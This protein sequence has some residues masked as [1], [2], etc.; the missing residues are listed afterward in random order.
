M[1]GT[2]DF[3]PWA[4]GGGANVLTAAAYAALA[5]R[6]LGAQTGTAVSA[7]FNT[8]MRQAS[9]ITSALAQWMA[10]NGINV[11]DDGILAD[12]VVD[13]NGQLRGTVVASITAL[14]ARLKTG[15]P[16][17]FVLGYYTAG[18]GGGGEY[19]YDSADITSADNGGTVIVAADGG[20]WK[21]Q[22]QGLITPEQFGAVGNG[23]ADDTASINACFAAVAAFVGQNTGDITQRRKYLPVLCT[24][25]YKLTTQVT[26]PA[27]VMVACE[28]GIFVNALVSTTTFCMVFAAGSHCFRLNI[29]AAG[30]SGAQLGTAGAYCDMIIGTVRVTNAGTGAS[31]I[32]SRIIGSRF[33]VEDIEV[34]GGFVGVD[35]GDGTVNGARL[36]NIDSL[37]STLSA[38]GVRFGS[39]TEEVNLPNL[40]VDTPTTTGIQA[41]GSRGIRVKGTIFGDDTRAVTPCTSGYAAIL[42]NT[43]ALSD[44]DLDLLVNNTASVD[45]TTGTAIKISNCS[46][47]VIRFSASRS[48]LSTGNA[49]R[50]K[51]AVEYGV[52]NAATL[53]V[54]VN[55]DP[56][57][58]TVVGTQVGGLE[59][60]GNPNSKFP[61][62]SATVATNA[63]TIGVAA[64]LAFDFRSATLGSGTPNTVIGTPA[65][66]VVPAGATLGT[67]NAVPSRLLVA[68]MNNAG[69]LEL[70]VSNIAGGL[71]ADETG[72]MSTTAISAGATAANVWYSNTGRANLPYRIIGFIDS[73]QATAGQ[74]ATAPSTVQ[75]AG[76]NALTAL[77]SIGYGQV[78][79]SVTRISGTVYYNTTGKPRHVK[80]FGSSSTTSAVNLAVSVG[81]VSLPPTS[82]YSNGPGYTSSYDIIVPPGM[83]YSCTISATA[84]SPTLAAE[85]LF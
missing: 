40:I 74:W 51:N 72:L 6:T 73:T 54:L 83:A 33:E 55:P 4:I 81:G 59:Y 49:H 18:D 84:G 69:V 52:G 17:C 64:P 80:F 3:V 46:Q 2:N 28:G 67:T 58:A 79:Q 27:G 26:V 34:D 19:R 12:M 57:N 42:G 8:A 82:F 7:N 71:P 44:L 48:T 15:S 23:I 14:K 30:G 77:S 41:D 38:T 62:V 65:N 32:G 5:E 36:V 13:L 25:T 24:R 9:F 53:S 35:F 21:L 43:S 31:I 37:K 29:A 10:N 68:V 45:N 60:I 20:R 22:V 66:L 75:G 39:N 76:G 50:L 63:L 78:W 11:L 16:S 61:N 56:A 47:S 1:A 70:A 85:E